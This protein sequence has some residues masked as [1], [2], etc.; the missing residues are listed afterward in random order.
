M[1]HI[2]GQYSSII[3][4]TDI[5][6]KELYAVISELDANENFIISISNVI[7]QVLLWKKRLKQLCKEQTQKQEAKFKQKLME[8]NGIYVR[9]YA[10]A[11]CKYGKT[12]NEIYVPKF[13]E[14]HAFIRQRR[15]YRYYDGGAGVMMSQ[16]CCSVIKTNTHE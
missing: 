9:K 13:A 10:K 14:H 15:A 7:S 16:D 11:I 6:E 2:I 1:N 4:Y 3:S 12:I 8:I 5:Y